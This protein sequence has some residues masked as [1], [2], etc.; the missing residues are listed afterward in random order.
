MVG[1]VG[2]EGKAAPALH[3]V[4]VNVLQVVD[5]RGATE[6]FALGLAV[7]MD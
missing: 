1:Q 4:G 5:I 6:D 3:G 2:V 7:L